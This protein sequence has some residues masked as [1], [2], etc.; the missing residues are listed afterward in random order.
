M[1]KHLIGIG[2]F[3]VRL[4]VTTVMGAILL[5]SLVFGFNN[6]IIIKLLPEIILIMISAT[7]I[8]TAVQQVLVYQSELPCM[9]GMMIGMTTG[10]LAGFLV[11]YLIGATNG[12]FVGSVV[13]VTLGSL[14]GAATGRCSGIM[15]I[16]E[17]LMAGLMAGTMGAMLAPMVL[18]DHYGAF[19]TFFVLM[20]VVVFVALSIM[21]EREFT[22]LGKP[23]ARTLIA[24]NER[25]VALSTIIFTTL[26]AIVM[27]YAPHGPLTLVSSII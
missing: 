12:I 8:A 20:C 24:K 6:P 23:E 10:M 11:G 17:G 22:T 18:V 16:I 21:I 2:F 9:S 15:G 27:V 13:G 5:G 7:V 1:R 14:I 3:M 4:F 25:L 19:T 26:M